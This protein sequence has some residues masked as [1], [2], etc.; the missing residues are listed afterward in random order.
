MQT[1]NRK[2]D[3]KTDGQTCALHIDWPMLYLS[4]IYLFRKYNVQSQTK[5]MSY[6]SISL[7]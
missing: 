1:Y 5:R 4:N 6:D 2:T 7:Y 3:S